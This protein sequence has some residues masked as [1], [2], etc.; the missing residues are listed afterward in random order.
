[1]NKNPFSLY[2]FLGYAIP[3]GVALIFTWIVTH[4]EIYSLSNIITLDDELF[5]LVSWN[6]I[7]I[8]VLA[9]YLIGHLIA[10][11]SSLTIERFAVWNYRYPSR[12]LMQ[13]EKPNIIR[14]SYFTKHVF[15][16][17]KAQA[18]WRL[19]LIVVL[20][21]ISVLSLVLGRWLRLNNF[22]IKPFDNYMQE[23][24]KAKTRTL[25]NH[26]GLSKYNSISHGY[27]DINR[28]IYH[29]VYEKN[30]RQAKKMDNYVALYGF[31]RSI[32]LIFVVLSHY[33]FY[34][35]IINLA[36]IREFHTASYIFLLIAIAC[37]TYVFYL[38]FMKF[39]RRY[40]VEIFMSLV[41]DEDL[42]VKKKNET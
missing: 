15:W 37:I 11:V 31:L 1:M 36:T 32:S 28:I 26:L 4:S 38:S 20:M 7:L 19:L 34:Y 41:A 9:S 8:L 17:M 29:Y 27:V 33:L 39:Y 14:S 22:V 16:K 18:I 5:D 42:K 6:N 2:D 25:L 30:E 35:G 10:F 24:V 40:T 3:G 12:Y 13:K 21:P 23:A